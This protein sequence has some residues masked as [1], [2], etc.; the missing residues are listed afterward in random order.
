MGLK[1]FGNQS[2][3]RERKAFMVPAVSGDYASERITF[4]DVVSGQSPESFLG[5]TALFEGTPPSGARLELWL[6]KA[7]SGSEGHGDVT[8]DDYYYSGQCVLAVGSSAPTGD[9]ASYA[10]GTWALSGLTG[11]QLRVKSAGSGGEIGVSA[12]A[13]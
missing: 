11:A 3:G 1:N 10:S 13:I 7:P 8:D 4:G 9:T 5:V 2:K 6:P 12:W